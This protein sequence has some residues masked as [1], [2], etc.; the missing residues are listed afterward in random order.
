M[1]IFKNKLEKI[2]YND[3]Y[4][5]YYKGQINGNII[6][7]IYDVPGEVYKTRYLGKDD[8]V[9]GPITLWLLATKNEAPNMKPYVEVRLAVLSGDESCWHT[10]KE[11][12]IRV[13]TAKELTEYLDNYIKNYKNRRKVTK[14]K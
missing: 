9:A 11:H 7:S 4:N 5:S 10:Y 8:S 12:L 6:H 13:Y 1:A 2:L 14:F 3:K